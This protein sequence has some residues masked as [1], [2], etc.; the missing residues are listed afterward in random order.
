M[1]LAI[2]V[3]WI[4][5]VPALLNIPPPAPELLLSLSAVLYAIVLFFKVS[6]PLLKMPPPTFWAVLPLTVLLFT[7]ILVAE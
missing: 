6:A 7:N 5:T 3:F 1:L 4:V 2:I